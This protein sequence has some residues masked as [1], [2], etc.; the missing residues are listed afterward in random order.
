MLSEDLLVGNDIQDPVE[1][2]PDLLVVGTF[3]IAAFF[4]QPDAVPV[5]PGDD[6]DQHRNAV[7]FRFL[8]KMAQC[9]FPDPPPGIFRFE[10]QRNFRGAVVSLPFLIPGKV[11]ETGI[12]V[13]GP[14]QEGAVLFISY[15]DEF[16]ELIR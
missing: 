12:P 16:P 2:L 11:T 14:D 13:T 6:P 8:L 15:R 7:L 3:L 9:F 4:E 1:F 5:V 10:V